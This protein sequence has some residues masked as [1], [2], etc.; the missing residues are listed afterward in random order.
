MAMRN[1]F[2]SLLVLISGCILGVGLISAGA[3]DYSTVPPVGRTGATG[4]NCSVCHAGNPVDASGGSVTVNGLPTG[5]YTPGSTY[6]FNLT[7]THGASNRVRW[8]FSI[9]AVNAAGVAVGSFSSNNPNAAPNGSELSHLDAVSTSQQAS[10]TYNNLVWTA[11]FIG[12]GD[13]QTIRFYF[14]ANAANGS[15]SSG[16]FIYTG[17]KTVTTAAPV[18]TTN[19]WT[20]AVSTAWENPANWSCGQVPDS[21]MNVIVQAPAPNYPVV[22]S[23]A[24]CKSITTS[25]GVNVVV[26]SDRRLIVTGRQ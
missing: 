11:P 14:A 23:V 25:Q 13:N 7:I 15:F 26:N 21:T 6:N 1:V 12:T 17:S 4:S 10:Y 18:C 24:Y 5:T 2:I 19:N 8:G 3:P 16:D 9:I 22:N 20:G